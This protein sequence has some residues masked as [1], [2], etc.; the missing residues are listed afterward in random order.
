MYR[1]IS[2]DVCAINARLTV[3]LQQIKTVTFARPL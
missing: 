3:S 1:P 2:I